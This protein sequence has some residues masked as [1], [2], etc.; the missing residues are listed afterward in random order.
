MLLL[1]SR[2]CWLL[3]LLLLRSTRRRNCLASSLL[4][5]LVAVPHDLTV[6]SRAGK[7]G[8]LASRTA[9]ILVLVVDAPSASIPSQAL[10]LASNGFAEALMVHVI[11]Y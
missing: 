8:L 3:L 7:A 4:P 9:A 5:S 2:G 1:R 11:R 6:H 10:S